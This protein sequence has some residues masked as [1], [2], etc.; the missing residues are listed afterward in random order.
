M[1]LLIDL[2]LVLESTRAHAPPFNRVIAQIL[3]AD[4]MAL[5]FLSKLILVKV[6]RTHVSDFTLTLCDGHRLIQIWW[7]KNDERKSTTFLP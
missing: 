3:D 5:E 6:R 4:W 1:S 7:S 2:H